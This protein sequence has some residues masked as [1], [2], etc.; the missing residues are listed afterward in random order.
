MWSLATASLT[1]PVAG[2]T[3]DNNG[4]KS[5]K[6]NNNDDDDDDDVDRLIR[7]NGSR[8]PKGRP[9]GGMKRVMFLTALGSVVFLNFHALW[10]K[11]YKDDRPLSPKEEDSL[12]FSEFFS[13]QP[14]KRTLGE[15]EAEP[16]PVTA[17]GVVNVSEVTSL[18]QQNKPQQP[19]NPQH[20]PQ[21]QQQLLPEPQQAQQQQPQLQQSQQQQQ[22]A[23]SSWLDVA[24]TGTV[25]KGIIA[26]ITSN[27]APVTLSQT[28]QQQ[29][30]LPVNQVKPQPSS[31]RSTKVRRAK[32]LMGIM[33]SELPNDR[34]YRRRHRKLFMLWN[35]K[36]VCSLPDFIESFQQK[37]KMGVAAAPGAATTTKD[38]IYDDCELI[39]TFVAGGNKDPQGPTELVQHNASFPLV[40]TKPIKTR[41]Q[42]LN[43]P[44]T[45]L[46]NIR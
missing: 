34:V 39:Y 29:P 27:V 10:S 11:Q 2:T 6:N 12:L 14:S 30:R 41:Q 21:Q 33:S 26:N 1:P 18:L 43:D 9:S 45:T 17:V 5:S 42:D 4:W 8:S 46:L 7:T 20:L 28:T 22:Q 44:D 15:H 32:V 16:K 38:N 3:A 25:I 13:S 40:L 37:K 36:R 31:S 23:D 35:D 19:P 24:K